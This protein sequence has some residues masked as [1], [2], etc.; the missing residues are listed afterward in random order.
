MGWL[1]AGSWGLRGKQCNYFGR[2]C[3]Q[4]TMWD[5]SAHNVCIVVYFAC[6]L[7]LREDMEQHCML[8]CLFGGHLE[9]GAKFGA[10]SGPNS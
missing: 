3:T 4:C 10:S 7:G 8:G 6:C 2:P 9:V 1:T 5:N